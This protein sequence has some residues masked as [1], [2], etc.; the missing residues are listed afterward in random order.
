[1]VKERD[2]HSPPREIRDTPEEDV[3]EIN[4]GKTP[5]EDEDTVG[6]EP[7]PDEEVQT[8]DGKEA[9]VEQEDIRVDAEI[10]FEAVGAP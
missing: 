10:Q 4:N 9:D 6:D 8:P 7:A 5:H 2:I 3:A 1:M